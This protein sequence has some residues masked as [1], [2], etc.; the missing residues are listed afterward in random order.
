MLCM[1]R[2]AFIDDRL[3]IALTS[4]DWQS[5][6]PAIEIEVF[7]SHLVDEAMAIRLRAF[8]AIIMMRRTPLGRTV[9]ESLPRLRLILTQGERNALIDIDAA[10]ELGV[11]VCGTD[12]LH[13]A[14]A[15][16]TW[17]LI[18][19]ACRHLP[20]EDALI[21]SG[22]WVSPILGVGL[23]G[24]TLGILGLGR[25][26]GQVAAVG[27]AFGMN[28][29][30][31]SQNLTD[32]RAADHGVRRVEKDTLF[33][34]SDVISIHLVLASRTTKLV[35][36]AE[37]ALM[38][39]TAILVNTSRAPIVDESALVACLKERRIAGA[40]LDVFDQEPLPSGHPFLTLDN[41]AMTPHIGSKVEDHY[42]LVYG[43]MLESI[44]GFLTGAIIRPINQPAS[45]RGP[46]IREQAVSGSDHGLVAAGT[47]S[48]P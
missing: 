28:V 4:A 37:L 18:L 31:W 11:Q 48:E 10:T 32:A 22:G 41:L 8:D 33:A 25:M 17:A 30:A 27:K 40:G 7:P 39:R 5:L 26:G 46:N 12:A 29:V 24:K 34:D 2:V 16:L 9:I 20:Q 38:K 47:I 43:Q 44:R 15:E 21:R 3:G 35:G 19:G 23:A 1:M 13:S 6:A 14:T 36:A 42:R 45:P